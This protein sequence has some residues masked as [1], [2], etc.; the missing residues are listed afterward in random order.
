MAVIG[1]S[2]PNDVIS[3]TRPKGTTIAMQV[4]SSRQDQKEL[5]LLS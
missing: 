5:L 2:I 3:K 1:D 4:L